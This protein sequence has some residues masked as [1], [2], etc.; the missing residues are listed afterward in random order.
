[1]LNKKLG[2][3]G[4]Q[5]AA[6]FLQGRGYKV[7]EKNFHTRYGEIDLVCRYKKQLVF[8]EVK[9]RSSRLF[10]YPEEAITPAKLQ[11]ISQAAELYLEK[12]NLSVR[13]RIEVVAILINHRQ[14]SLNIQHLTNI[15]A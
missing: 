8:V 14:Q 3:I 5:T 1:M 2:Q 10:G 9:T 15:S 12:K 4:E 6:E 13:W 11:K 7:I